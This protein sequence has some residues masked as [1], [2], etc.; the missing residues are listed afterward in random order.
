MHLQW[1]RN[2]FL[3]LV[4]QRNHDPI[5]RLTEREAGPEKGRQSSGGSAQMS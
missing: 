4:G 1:N 2:V 3:G 5:G